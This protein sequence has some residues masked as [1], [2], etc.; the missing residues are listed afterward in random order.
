MTLEEAPHAIGINVDAGWLAAVMSASGLPVDDNVASIRTRLLDTGL[1]AFSRLV[2]LDV[3]YRL[4]APHLPR[5]LVLKLPS[6]VTVNDNRALAFDLYRR[7]ALFY[8][9]VAKALKLRV[10]RCYWSSLDTEPHRPALL[11]EDLDSWSRAD[12]L[13]GI[14]VAR[15]RQAV[16]SIAEMHAQWWEAPRLAHVTWIPCLGGWTKGE[17]VRI[18]RAHWPGFV[19]RY[20]S[21]LPP[22][23]LEAGARLCDELEPL[24][25]ETAACPR[26]L[27]HGDFRADNLFFGDGS[28]CEVAV[29]DW[30][31]CCSGRGAFDVAYLLCQSMPVSVR[32]R[33]GASILWTWHE[34]LVQHGVRR[35]SFDDAIRDYER[36]ARLCVAYAVVGTA[37]EGADDR[38]LT[39]ALAQVR[40]SFSAALELSE[41]VL[42]RGGRRDG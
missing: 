16:R 5:S 32:R 33:H 12:Q 36:G 19:D 20:A 40:R 34:A 13:A 15:A 1:G 42:L 3:T 27:V 23:S 8:R 28:E 14:S 37:L 35:Y 22:G 21:E 6:D 30:Q 17:L 39:L 9:D 11:I 7:E 24:L 4:P 2:R 41:G 10:P 29:I 18:Y 38:A 26:T 25:H 31:L